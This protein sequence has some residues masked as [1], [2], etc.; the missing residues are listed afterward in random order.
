MRT[1]SMIL[2][3]MTNVIIFY[4]SINESQ[5]C[6]LQLDVGIKLCLTCHTNAAKASYFVQAGG[7]IHARVGNTLVDIQLT[8]RPHIT[9]LA[10]TLERTLGV[11]AL[12]SV[13]TWVRA[14]LKHATPRYY[15]CCWDKIAELCFNP[16]EMFA[17]QMQRH[18]PSEH[19]STSWLQEAPMYPVGQVQM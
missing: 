12:P 14:C 6:G 1:D 10:L 4:P 11:Y 2:E 9:P 15:K 19:S 3:A 16:T 5:S 13:L 7:L 17:A 18:L 8:T